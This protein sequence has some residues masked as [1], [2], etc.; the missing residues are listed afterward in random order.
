MSELLN[1][2]HW[3]AGMERSG[4]LPGDA[5]M[6]TVVADREADI[7][8]MFA[9]RPGSAGVVVRASHDRVAGSG[10]GRV[11]AVGTRGCLAG[12]FRTGETDSPAGCAFWLDDDQP[13]PEPGTGDG[14]SPHAG[15]L[16]GRGP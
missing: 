8:G 10:A 4:E 12:P 14:C 6:V 5:S 2:C 11:S 3:M 13:S 1:E 16:S 9:C 7:Y 15:G